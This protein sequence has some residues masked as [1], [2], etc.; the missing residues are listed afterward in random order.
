M[1]AYDKS[2]FS[3]YRPTQDELK[4]ARERQEHKPTA[5]QEL[6]ELRR[7]LTRL[8]S[9]GHEFAHDKKYELC[10]GYLLGG[11]SRVLARKPGAQ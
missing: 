1:R 8:L 6:V 5:E 3:I 7:E 10:C 11:I 2:L 9:E 4:E